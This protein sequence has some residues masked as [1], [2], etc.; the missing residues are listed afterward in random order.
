[1][2]KKVII[3]GNTYFSVMIYNYVN[4][5]KNEY[6]NS[7]EIGLKWYNPYTDL[8]YGLL[9][10]WKKAFTITEFLSKS[11]G[12]KINCLTYKKDNLPLLMYGVLLF[13]MMRNR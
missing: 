6:P 9:G 2:G 1:M 12:K 3:F 10:I 8:I 5:I 13:K 11:H 4:G 7:Y